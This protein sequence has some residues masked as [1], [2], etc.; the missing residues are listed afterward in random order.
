M[1]AG[2]EAAD[3]GVAATPPSRVTPEEARCLMAEVAARMRIPQ[4]RWAYDGR[5]ALYTRGR[6]PQDVADAL[7]T[8]ITL[9]SS[10]MRFRDLSTPKVPRPAPDPGPPAAKYP[11]L[12]FRPLGIA[13]V[14]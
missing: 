8:G 12:W 9:L 7:S 4:G 2:N 5:A 14:L 3:E 10:D 6:F 13:G 1:L 11:I